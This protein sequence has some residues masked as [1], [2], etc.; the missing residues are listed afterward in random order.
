MTVDMPVLPRERPGDARCGV[1]RHSVRMAGAFMKRVA[2]SRRCDE[3]CG[4]GLVLP[5]VRAKETYPP[6]TVPS[7]RVLPLPLH[8]AAFAVASRGVLPCP[9]F[10]I[11][12][13]NSS[14]GMASM[15]TPVV[16]AVVASMTAGSLRRTRRFRPRVCPLPRPEGK[17][18]T[19]SHAEAKHAA[20]T[21]K[22]EIMATAAISNTLGACSRRMNGENAV[23]DIVP[24]GPKITAHCPESCGPAPLAGWRPT[25]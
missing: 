16:R 2:R 1:R 10:R 18:P 9:A 25:S 21:K 13:G 5:E 6:G 7:R 17:Y 12:P 15:D 11:G 23:A 24:A 20:W 19:A 4:L 8:V 14:T 3:G 22:K